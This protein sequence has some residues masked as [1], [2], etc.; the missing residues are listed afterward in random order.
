MSQ[1]IVMAEGDGDAHAVPQLLRRMLEERGLH[2]WRVDG[3]PMRIGDVRKSIQ[4]GNLEKFVRYSESRAGDA[5]LICQDMDDGCAAEI[6]LEYFRR[7]KA[8]GGLKKRYGV[9]FIVREFESLFLHSILS[10]VDKFPEYNW[11]VAS[12]DPNKR[13]EE[14]RDAKGQLAR[15]FGSGRTYKETFD[16]KRLVGGLDFNILRQR[17]RSFQHLDKLLTE[18]T[19]ENSSD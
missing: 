19:D 7:I 14:V 11:R 5:V 16:Q 17:S 12:I 10:I 8:I 13:W 9:S 6:S 2:H 15:L 18:L 1:I 4:P 3:Q